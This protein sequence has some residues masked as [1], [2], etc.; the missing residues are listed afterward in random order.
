MNKNIFFSILLC[1]SFRS[2]PCLVVSSMESCGV[3]ISSLNK[4]RIAAKLSLLNSKF[5][6]TTTPD[7]SF[8][9]QGLCRNHDKPESNLYGL[10]ESTKK[11]DE[12]CYL[13]AIFGKNTDAFFENLKS[14]TKNNEIV[15]FRLNITEPSGE[16]SAYEKP[17]TFYFSVKAEDYRDRFSFNMLTAPLKTA[18]KEPPKKPSL[19]YSLAFVIILWGGITYVISFFK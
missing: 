5:S 14:Y 4:H 17:R 1:S 6:P 12:K 2:E 11:P 9:L 18:P 10:L 13:E 15:H 19:F 16:T 8:N 3:S 7:Y